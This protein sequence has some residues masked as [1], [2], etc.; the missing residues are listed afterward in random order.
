MYNKIE[1]L[2][3]EILMKIKE[4]T[5]HNFR[6]FYDLTLSFNDDY[7]ILVGINGAGKSTI[8]EAIATAF[9]TYL[10]GFP[11][12]KA[13]GLSVDQV[14]IRTVKYGSTFSSE[15]QYSTS[16]EVTAQDEKENTYHW[17]R[18]KKRAAGQSAT[19]TGEEIQNYAKSL[20]E[21]KKSGDPQVILPV[22]VNFGT[23]RLYK[24][25]ASK[26]QIS[27][28]HYLDGYK[29][30]LSSSSNSKDMVDWIKRMTM[31]E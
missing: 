29:N 8:L 25:K 26:N 22:I 17:G 21:S 18:A 10:Q 31:V 14:L 19:I 7:T 11:D 30:Y 20:Y 3:K 23:D 16:I 12:S 13:P 1:V 9:G 2:R 5:L 27:N 28:S 15:R 4:L 6:C 24:D